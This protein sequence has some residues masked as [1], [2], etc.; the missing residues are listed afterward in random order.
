MEIVL[1]PH[2]REHC[3]RIRLMLQRAHFYIDTSPLGS[4]K[5]ITTCK[6]A[7][8]YGVPMLI[9]CP[10]STANVW[11]ET[12]KK[13]GITIIDVITYQSLSSQQNRQPKHGYLTRV[14]DKESRTTRFHPTSKWIDLVRTGVFLVFDEIQAIK[15]L[16]A[17]YYAA[18]GMI[19]PILVY[20]GV[21]RFIMLSGTPNDEEQHSINLMRLLGFI[22]ARSLHLTNA[23][24]GEF[25]LE[26]AEE[27]L[28]ICRRIDPQQTEKTQQEFVLSKTNVKHFCY[29]LFISVIKKHYISAMPPPTMV[30]QIDIKNGFFKLENS[31]SLRKGIRQLKVAAAFDEEEE[32]YVSTEADFGQ[33]TR[34][35]TAIEDAKL[36]IMIRLATQRLEENPKAKVVLFVNYTSSIR[37]LM[38]VLIRFKPMEFT[39]QTSLTNRGKILE[40]FN[41][42][43]NYRLI[44]ANIKV[45]GV[46]VSMHDTQGD[47]PRYV[48]IIPN[49]SPISL[50]QASRRT[51]RDG[52]LT[53]SYVRF[54]YG[55]DGGSLE[56]SILDSLSRKGKTMREV[57]DD[58]ATEGIKFPGEYDD[59]L[60]E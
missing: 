53:D 49:Y 9:I 18:S 54:V 23:K 5:T 21:S 47:R 56:K 7:K 2:Q 28:A 32:D 45:G 34:A 41:T 59:E 24:T 30:S 29:R 8:D 44:V 27:L 13:Y 58:R 48:Y 57:I 31:E 15:N 3:D 40:Q 39:G 14:D 1:R 35:L 10:K 52:S 37:T 33:I 43:D 55:R 16:N 46:G 50:H 42:D 6:M 36:P 17:T 4:G 25:R 22:R 51:H 20:G 19:N 26:G 11:T 60:E 12:S 38:N